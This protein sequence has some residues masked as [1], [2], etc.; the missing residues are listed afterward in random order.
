[1]STHAERECV[2]CGKKISSSYSNFLDHQNRC[3]G[4]R[5]KRVNSEERKKT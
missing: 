5:Y 3:V 2:Y 4:K 1:M